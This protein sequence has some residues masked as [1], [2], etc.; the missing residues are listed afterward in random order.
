MEIEIWETSHLFLLLF[1]GH[2]FVVLSSSSGNKHAH[3]KH[4]VDGW[5]LVVIILPACCLFPPFQTTHI[6]R[7]LNWLLPFKNK[8]L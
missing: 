6:L 8:V 4:N 5:L 3:K 2:F 1:I 7:S